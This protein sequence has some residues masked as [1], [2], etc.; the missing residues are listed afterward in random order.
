MQ[1]V[2]RCVI[3]NSRCGVEGRAER[4]RRKSWHKL[5]YGGL[6][7]EPRDRRGETGARVWKKRRRIRRQFSEMKK[8]KN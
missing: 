4:K 2:A 7:S 5:T 3:A 1:W 8:K 6:V